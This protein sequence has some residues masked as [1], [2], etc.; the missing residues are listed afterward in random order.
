MSEPRPSRRILR[1]VG[2]VLAGILVTVI[3]S[4]GTD[5]AMFAI[6]LFP[7][8]GQPMTDVHWRFCWRRS[9]A[10]CT[11]SQGASS[12]RASHPIVP[13]TTRS[14]WVFWALSSASSGLQPH[15]T[16]NRSSGRSGIPWRSSSLP[17]RRPGWEANCACCNAR[18]QTRPAERCRGQRR[19]GAVVNEANSQP[20]ILPY[21]GGFITARPNVSIPVPGAAALHRRK[22]AA[23]SRN[24]GS[25]C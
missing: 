12:R 16:Q 23:G 4:I 5:A 15:G 8:P 25:P 1:R 7:S 22:R 21:C 9:I 13:C 14:C 19:E 6:G 2:A 20:G 10:R 24:R 3:L 17:C 11:A 18:R